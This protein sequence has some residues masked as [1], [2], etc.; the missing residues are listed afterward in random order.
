[1]PLWSEE[2]ITLSSFQTFHTA[3]CLR[4]SRDQESTHAS[5]HS[6]PS[7]ALLQGS[8]QRSPGKFYKQ[9]SNSYPL[10][11]SPQGSG[12]A[13]EISQMLTPEKDSRFLLDLECFC[14][15]RWEN[16]SLY[17][18]ERMNSRFW[19]SVFSRCILVIF[20][21]HGRGP[22]L[23]KLKLKQLFLTNGCV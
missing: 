5:Q 20:C 11:G 3:V 19:I 9:P 6:Q 10:G 14:S 16:V 22:D 17:F 23:S 18:K 12:A 4:Q 7:A 8:S 2:Q 15:S 13:S 21:V 1:M